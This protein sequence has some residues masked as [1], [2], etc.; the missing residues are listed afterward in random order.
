MP[1]SGRFEATGG[2]GAGSRGGGGGGG[3]RIALLTS[4]GAACAVPEFDCP[5][6]TFLGTYAA[7]GGSSS[8]FGG[9]HGG[10][11]TVYIED[12]YSGFTTLVVDNNGLATTNVNQSADRIASYQSRSTDAARTWLV[13]DALT[14]P[15]AAG[16]GATPD[17][18]FDVVRLV[19]RAQLAV[20][21]HPAGRALLVQVERL[22]GDSLPATFGLLHVGAQQTVTIVSAQIY[23]PIS[24]RLYAG[25]ELRLPST[26]V[27]HQNPMWWNGRLVGVDSLTVSDCQV[28]VGV[29]ASTLRVGEAE[30]P[31][32][33]QLATLEIQFF[34]VL[35]VTGSTLQHTLLASTIHVQGFGLVTASNLLVQATSRL[36]VDLNGNLAADATGFA[37]DQGPNADS[38]AA[39]GSAAGGSHAGLGGQGTVGN[40]RTLPFGSILR[41][42]TAGAGGTSGTVTG[43]FGGG[44][45][46]I[47]TPDLL[48]DGVISSLGQ[49][50][51]GPLS[52][53]SAGAGAGGSVWI[54]TT[55]LRGFG[56]IDVSG[57]SA[58]R[59]GGGGSGGLML[60]E[61]ATAQSTAWFG[62]M[63]AAGG[64][65]S[66]EPGAAGL[67]LT[68]ALESDGTTRTMLTLDN[69][70]R[71]ALLPAVAA[72]QSGFFELDRSAVG[73]NPATTYLSFGQATVPIRPG[74]GTDNYEFDAIEMRGAARLAMQARTPSTAVTL[75]VKSFS[76]DATG[77][78]HVAADQQVRLGEDT[79][80]TLRGAIIVEENGQ[81]IF[82]APVTLATPCWLGVQGLINGLTDMTVGDGSTLLVGQ[83]A[84]TPDKTPGTLSFGTLTVQFGG[85]VRTM[86][87]LKNRF[88]V[89]DL[90]LNFGGFF[91]FVNI[92][93]PTRT[94]DNVDIEDTPRISASYCAWSDQTQVCGCNTAPLPM[95][96]SQTACP[97]MDPR[98]CS[99]G[100]PCANTSA[101]RCDETVC[102]PL[103]HNLTC[104]PPTVFG[105]VFTYDWQP[106]T[107]ARQRS[108]AACQAATCYGFLNN[109][110]CPTGV[111]V[112]SSASP[113][114]FDPCF[115]RGTLSKSERRVESS[116]RFNF[117]TVVQRSA[118]RTNMVEFRY[119][120]NGTLVID[121]IPVEQTYTW[122]ETI[123]EERTLTWWNMTYTVTC[124]HRTSLILNSGENCWLPPGDHSYDVLELH[125]G[126]WIELRHNATSLSR[127][128]ILAKRL[129]LH[130]G[131]AIRANALGRS[132]D[133]WG[134]DTDG[135]TGASHLGLG[136][137]TRL[138]RPRGSFLQPIYPG[139]RAGAVAGGGVVRIVASEFMQLDGTVEANGAASGTAG[140]AG[141]SVWITATELRGQG[142]V[143]ALGGAGDGAG[144]GGGG[145]V[146]VYV[147]LVNLFR[148]TMLATGGTSARSVRGGPGAVYFEERG[149]NRTLMYNGGGA[150]V[151]AFV[152]DETILGTTTFSVGTLHVNGSISLLV[153]R[154]NLV[155]GTLVGDRTAQL[156]IMPQRFVTA[157]RCPRSL[158]D[159]GLYIEGGAFFSTPNDMLL[160]T[161]RSTLLS[162]FGNLTAPRV[163]KK[164]EKGTSAACAPQKHLF[165]TTGFS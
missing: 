128:N 125:G 52:S 150:D 92:P 114:E 77:A 139:G 38:R 6:F 115:G 134:L 45:L 159:F 68:R 85:A 163:S 46:R 35:N 146:A 21:P 103:T 110:P 67:V 117:T 120:D 153:E 66:S 79:N 65:G 162:L 132:P 62:Q 63:V 131:A 145:A 10:A 156:R 100:S 15:P 87:N 11:G 123:I 102:R 71:S 75:A 72:S 107:C 23:L 39:A 126:A 13:P 49:S 48:V 95:P 142:L 152:H 141:G 37:N 32:R 56:R 149:A 24:P 86:H 51:T 98:N 40:S 127:A 133:G 122:N 158:C 2:N 57:G 74:T 148:G 140:G 147:T 44:V 119:M 111:V 54:R 18:R 61:Y 88:E 47:E 97:Y 93:W 101:P 69:L 12:A 7:F 73:V 157:T 104:V 33:L 155:V 31:R 25:G 109:Q 136:G 28:S 42:A 106:Q 43:G 4:V 9:Q 82:P 83:R 124:D 130:A 5:G 26:V 144:G 143:R 80:L 27:M 78:L 154:F 30:I 161:R 121:Q 160:N 8:A 112:Y 118:T 19:G 116:G 58:L 105:P 3:G 41:P 94:A 91:D 96:N 59:V 164:T 17:Y 16:T 53:S 81:L 14:A 165:L 84:R 29:N 60:A 89:A 129:L 50:T 34:G 99:L 90:N 1:G 20:A 113:Y 70:G 22:E 108:K 36:Q 55:S 137:S 64:T 135:S 151:T 138:A 76:G